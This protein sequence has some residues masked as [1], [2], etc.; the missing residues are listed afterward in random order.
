MVLQSLDFTTDTAN[1][2]L[3]SFCHYVLS[4]K[5]D[6][7]NNFICLPQSVSI[8]SKLVSIYSTVIEKEI[9]NNNSTYVE[10]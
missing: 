6:D 10:R 5:R 4:I 1:N 8:N 2:G 9:E 7:S 3:D